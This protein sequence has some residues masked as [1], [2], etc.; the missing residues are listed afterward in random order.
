MCMKTPTIAVIGTDTTPVNAN[1][2]LATAS[3]CTASYGDTFS[4]YGTQLRAISMVD[5][6]T[7]IPEMFFSSATR[8]LFRFH[9]TSSTDA[10]AGLQIAWREE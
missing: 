3:S 6:E 5:E 1:R 8:Y 9:N 10:Q 4:G 7:T 2:D